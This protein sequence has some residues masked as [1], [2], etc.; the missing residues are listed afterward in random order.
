LKQDKFVIGHLSLVIC[1]KIAIR[2]LSS[3]IV[4]WAA[5]GTQVGVEFGHELSQQKLGGEGILF[6]KQSTTVGSAQPMSDFI[7]G[8]SGD[9]RWPP[10]L[11]QVGGK[12]KVDRRHV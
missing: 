10:S 11:G 3:V 7:K 5:N 9:K 4:F 2:H 8:A 12:V 1:I 6:V